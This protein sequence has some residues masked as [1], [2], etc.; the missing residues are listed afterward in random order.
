MGYAEGMAKMRD[1][2]GLQRGLGPQGVV[3]GCGS[4][5]QVRKPVLLQNSM[6]QDKKPGG[7]AAAGNGDQKTGGSFKPVKEVADRIIGQRGGDHCVH[8]R[9]CQ[10]LSRFCSVAT[11]AI[12]AREAF[13]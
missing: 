2:L 6:N 12:T 5:G 4:K 10:Q 1:L 13:G 7:I 11:F 8:D 3:D 9:C